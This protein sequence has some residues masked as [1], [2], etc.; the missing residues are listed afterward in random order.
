MCDNFK[1]N[2]ISCFCL[3]VLPAESTVLIGH[4]K[5]NISANAV[6]I[7]TYS[8]SDMTKFVIKM[9]DKRKTIYFVFTGCVEY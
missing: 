3:V 1:I 6:S 5:Y 7:W 4:V 9:I 8:T 2:A